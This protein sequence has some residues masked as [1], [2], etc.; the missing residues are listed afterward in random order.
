MALYLGGEGNGRDYSPLRYF[1]TE[2]LN[3]LPVVQ[4]ENRASLS[5]RSDTNFCQVLQENG[6][7]IEIMANKF[8]HGDGDLSPI[9]GM[10]APVMKT[11]RG[12]IFSFPPMHICY[13]V[14]K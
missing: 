13:K 9:A 4:P 8:R 10:T 2:H 14:I 1:P 7:M 6:N 3:L 11:A 5:D 12:K